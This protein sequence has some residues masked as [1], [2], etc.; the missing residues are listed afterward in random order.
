ML[1]G[2]LFVDI[3]DFDLNKCIECKKILNS[4]ATARKI[5][6]HNC[7]Y[8]KFIGNCT[9][10]YHILKPNDYWDFYKKE[11]KYAEENRDLPIEDRGLTYEEFYMLAFKYKTLVENATKLSYDLSVYFYSL[12]CHAIV[13]TFVGQKKEETV[14][15]YISSKGFK[16]EKVNGK[17][18]A[19]YGV[20]IEVTGNGEHF[21]IQV[22]PISFFKANFPDTHED[23]IDACRKREEILKLEGIDTY[24]IIYVLNWDT[25][26][27]NWIVNR[28]G[29][30]LF[31]INELFQYEKSDIKGT[32]VRL[33]LPAKWTNT[34]I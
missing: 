28:S 17:K 23:R 21:Y 8:S 15:Q 31:K 9:N 22:K 13:E 18:D 5:Y 10:L 24:Y 26:E 19:K 14:M 1:K 25:L 33:D 3:F 30:V 2:R 12:V 16:A 34:L 7:S 20:D 27:L 4:N 29:G 32:I 11:L 6:K